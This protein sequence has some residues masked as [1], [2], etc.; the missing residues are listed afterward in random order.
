MNR[1]CAWVASIAVSLLMG[2]TAVA[3]TDCDSAQES[4]T[5]DAIDEACKVVKCEE[6]KLV[7]ID[8]K[9]TLAKLIEAYEGQPVYFFVFGTWCP[10]CRQEIE[11]VLN[12]FY[13]TYGARGVR[14]V[15]VA[16]G[17]RSESALKDYI[18]DMDIEFTVWRDP[19]MTTARAVGAFGVPHSVFID[20]DGNVVYERIGP[21]EKSDLPALDAFNR[22]ADSKPSEK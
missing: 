9:E 7:T 12:D 4:S 21:F 19:G 15:G 6:G 16:V 13:K 17:Q 14:F 10:V 5:L 22:I 18:A 8:S 1:A 3:Q 11:T 2:V 20:A